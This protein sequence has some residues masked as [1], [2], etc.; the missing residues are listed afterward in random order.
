MFLR[1]VGEYGP[2]LSADLA[3]KPQQ[4]TPIIANSRIRVSG[5]WDAA[6]LNKKNNSAKER[7]LN[8]TKLKS[9]YTVMLL[10]KSFLSLIG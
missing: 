8:R 1:I 5:S 3:L 9:L 4:N 2:G 6:F 10:N 7:I